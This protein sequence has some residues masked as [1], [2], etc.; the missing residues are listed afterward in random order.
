MVVK[1]VTLINA[2]S[3]QCVTLQIQRLPIT[4]GRD[5]HVADQ[6]V[7]K[8]LLEGFHTLRHS[9]GVCRMDSQPSNSV[10]RPTGRGVG[11]QVFPDTLPT[12]ESHP[13][14]ALS[15][16]ISLNTAQRR[17]SFVRLCVPAEHFVTS[18]PVVERPGQQMP[19]GCV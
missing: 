7:R 10:F 9:D 2:G 8:T 19:M 4:L 13:P 6:H 17:S 5:S 11:N 16:L 12:T 15:R 18:G 3:E 14:P 1:Q